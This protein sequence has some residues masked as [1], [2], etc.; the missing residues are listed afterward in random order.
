M[1]ALTELL[2]SN[3]PWAAQRAQDALNIQSALTANQISG[4][5]AAEMLKDLIATDALNK[6]ANDF[7][8]RTKLV[9]AIND[10]ITIAEGLTSIPGL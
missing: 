10:L 7:T 4:A 1:S 2:G 9:N 8:T 5:Q 3:Y 6:E